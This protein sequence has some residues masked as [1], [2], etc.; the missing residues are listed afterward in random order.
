[1][2]SKKN[3][4]VFKDLLTKSYMKKLPKIQAR[5]EIEEFFS[6]IKD[7]TPKQVKKIKRLAMRHSIKL[8][9][10]RKLFCKKC[11]SPYKNSKTRT[12]N[13]IKSITCENCGHVSR[14]RIE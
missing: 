3:K 9:D 6:N 7:K 2:N 10:K 13:S 12:K 1:M 5:E 8:G 11:L 14:W 4:E